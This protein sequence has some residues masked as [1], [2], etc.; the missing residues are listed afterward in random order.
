MIPP[1]D[2]FSSCK[3]WELPCHKS[4]IAYRRHVSL[5]C[6]NEKFAVFSANF[7][8][9]S[10]IVGAEIDQS[11]RSIVLSF[12]DSQVKSRRQSLKQID[13]SHDSESICVR[14]LKEC[15]NSAIAVTS[16]DENLSSQTYVIIFCWNENFG[17]FRRFPYFKNP[18][19]SWNW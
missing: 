17:I 9:E 19:W 7:P 12:S 16:Y 14:H 8:I 2:S 10:N 1:F 3:V 4:K 13:G 11:R 18:G 5:W 15:W 6:W